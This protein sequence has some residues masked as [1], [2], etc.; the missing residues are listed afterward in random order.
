M[1]TTI[2]SNGIPIPKINDKDCLFHDRLTLII[3]PSGSGKSALTQHILNTLRDKIPLIVVACPTAALNGDYDGIVPEQCIYDDLTKPMIQRIFQR[4][5]NAV[6]MYKQVNDVERIMPI[7]ELVAAHDERAKLQRVRDI[8]NNG[9]RKIRAT[10]GPDDVEP[11]LIDLQKVYNKKRL[12]IMRASINAHIGRVPMD[13]LTEEQRSIVKNFNLNPSLVL[14]ADD[15]MATVREWGGLDETKKL[16]YQGRHYKLTT[17]LLCQATILL[18]P[19]LRSN[20]HITIFTTEQVANSYVNKKSSGFSADDEKRLTKIAKTLF[21]SSHDGTQTNYKKMVLLGSIIET[22]NP[23]QYIIGTPRK[24]RF[25][26]SALWELC[27]IVKKS[28]SSVATAS[29]NRMFAIK[30]QPTA[31]D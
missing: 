22:A 3:G 4:Q 15:C 30:S 27:D 1:T 9:C 18:S 7:F 5:Q 31:S 20:A 16:F 12:R 19:Q 6:E 28:S 14:I 10:Y 11:V 26:S 25:G 21:D 13:R 24:R 17:I 2:Y 23:I 29:F 8:Y